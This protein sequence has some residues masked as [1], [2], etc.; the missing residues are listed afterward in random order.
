MK[1]AVII[2]GLVILAIVAYLGYSGLFAK[3]QFEEKKFGGETLVYEEHIGDYSKVGPVM[4]ALYRRLK[5]EDNIEAEVGFGIYYD[6]P[7]EVP[8]DQL[9]SEVGCVLPEQYL[10]E[11]EALG[12]KYKLKE[13]PEQLCLV[14]E[15]PYRNTTSIMLGIFKAYPV[16]AKMAEEKG[17]PP[18]AVMERYDIKNKRIQYIMP[19]EPA[20]TIETQS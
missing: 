17:Y 20:E 8:K 3:V 11:V 18:N 6:K 12:L 16:L 19:I 4:D 10:G 5:D 1:K 2:V 9:R 13:F 7:G 14:A 15:L